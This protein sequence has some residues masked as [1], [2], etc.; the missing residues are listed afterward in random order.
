MFQTNKF[1]W[2]GGVRMKK[3]IEEAPRTRSLEQRRPSLEP[4]LNIY[5]FLL[6]FTIELAYRVKILA[7]PKV[8]YRPPNQI[9]GVGGVARG[10]R[11]V[12]SMY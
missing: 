1:K 3:H 8:S 2:L 9:G 10:V 11:W 7:A 12:S 6:S 4:D 5:L